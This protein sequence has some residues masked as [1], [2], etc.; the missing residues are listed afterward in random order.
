[1]PASS[2]DPP[3]NGPAL[4]T[5]LEGAGPRCV[6][7]DRRR[8]TAAQAEGFES[9][10]TRRHSA[11]ALATLRGAVTR[12]LEEG[13]L[14]LVDA[15]S[16]HLL[17]AGVGWSCLCSSWCLSS[18]GLIHS[19]SGHARVDLLQAH[20]RASQAVGYDRGLL[21]TLYRSWCRGGSRLGST[22]CS[23]CQTAIQA[24]VAVSLALAPQRCSYCSMNQFRLTPAQL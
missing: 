18:Q 8:C 22:R 23:C 11:A 21:L 5:G 19:N 10:S 12:P 1:M 4:G 9:W 15:H 6:S 3:I 2:G 17:A 24:A 14:R 20:S 16:V 13:I 7:C